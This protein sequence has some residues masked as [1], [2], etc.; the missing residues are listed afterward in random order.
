MR[1]RRTCRG[2]F[3]IVELLLSL[4]IVSMVLTSALVALDAAFKGYRATTDSASTHVV[5]R[6][7]MHRIVAMIRTGREFG[8]FPSD[9]L[10]SAQNPITSDFIEFVSKVDPVTGNRQV[11][12]IEFR[13]PA[14]NE[15][16]GA[17][18]FMLFEF[19]SAGGQVGETK[20][21]RMIPNVEAASF[22]LTYSVGP[23]LRLAT[24]DLLIRPNDDLDAIGMESRNENTSQPIRLVGSAVPR[25]L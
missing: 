23:R 17:L 11:T 16:Y 18:W 1:M 15:D 9:V 4:A 22:T 25:R 7:V 14:D 3:S 24:I 6:L 21:A 20:E 8:P 19:D 5:S 2:G 10:D 12:R 13:P